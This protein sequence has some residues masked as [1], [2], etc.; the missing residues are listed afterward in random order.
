MARA[1][2]VLAVVSVTVPLLAAAGCH[3]GTAGGR[4]SDA[5]MDASL[6]PMPKLP[7]PDADCPA[8]AAGGNGVCPLNFCGAPKSVAALGAGETAE[9]GADAVCTPG[10]SCVPD[11][12]IAGGTALQ[13]RCVTPLASAAPFG[14]ACTRGAG[15][16]SRC[17]NDALCI[18]AAG[19][20]GAPFCSALCRAD[21]DCPAGGYCLEYRSAALP[22]GS[23]VNLGFCTPQAKIPGTACAREADCP[24]DQGCVSV[25]ART[26]LQT[27][28][29]AAGKKSTGD[30]CTN[31]SECRSGHC[32]DR[33][34]HENPDHGYCSATC[35]KSSDCGADQRCARIV[36]NNNGTPADPR[37][38]LVVGLC[39]ALFAAAGGCTSNADCTANGA[40]TCSTK[41]G[42][43]Y[44]AGAPSGAPC[45]DD[46][47]CDLGAVCTTGARFPGG[48]CQTF[49]C[50]PD[51]APGS[52][53]SCPGAHPTCVQRGSDEPINA[54]Y[55]GC[56]RSGDCSR[57]AQMYACEA[58]ST[59][60]T[61]TD[62]G[63]SSD[64]AEGADAGAADAGPD[65]EAGAAQ[66][67]SICIF[68]Q[69]V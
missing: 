35:G 40:D 66:P 15:T 28:Q 45:T 60:S 54:C 51:A 1:R 42:L 57:V 33:D 61:G 5:G 22:N 53:D 50:A 3:S 31:G 11:V 9:L 49:G 21:A 36:L 52:V 39:Q 14:A 26:R 41:Y 20:T 69:G 7:P 27:C 32:Y 46:V 38:D 64:A 56:V 59:L 12:P 37:D 24:A 68:D 10:Y 23:Y 63:A 62:A 67:A 16:A 6:E 29:A 17:A 4:R 13:L 30:A 65:A 34:F 58:P 19:T 8:D 18:D 47:G 48:Y 55:E 44:K 43:C 25:G 2:G